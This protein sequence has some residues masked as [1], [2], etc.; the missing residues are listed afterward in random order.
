MDLREHE[1]PPSYELPRM[2]VVDFLRRSDVEQKRDGKP[3]PRYRL[4][5]P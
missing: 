1:S 5:E 4:E 3:R 2:S